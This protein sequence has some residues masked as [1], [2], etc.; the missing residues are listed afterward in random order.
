MTTRLPCLLICLLVV[1]I[2]G[3]D[4]LVVT[5][6][7]Y[8][9]QELA[10]SWPP[11]RRPTMAAGAER[12]TVVPPRPGGRGPRP[13]LAQQPPL[14]TVTPY[15]EW[16]M[17]HMVEDTLGRIGAPV[18]PDLIVALGDSDPQRRVD[19]ARILARIG[20]EAEAAVPALTNALADP[21]EPVRLAATR[22]LGQIGPA[23]ERSVRPLLELLRNGTPDRSQG[24]PPPPARQ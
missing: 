13:E 2:C 9:V 21:Y 8:D 10:K 23:A 22:A 6:R 11:Y 18:V 20:P 12:A 5:Q 1:G 24:S 14:E 16:G 7:Q 3:C 17:D 19:A 15:T 4:R